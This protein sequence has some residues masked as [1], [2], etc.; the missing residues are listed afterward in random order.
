MTKIFHAF[1]CLKISFH[2]YQPTF[3][4]KELFFFVSKSCGSFVNH[5]TSKSNVCVKLL[6]FKRNLI[7][8][9]GFCHSPRQPPQMKHQKLLFFEQLELE[10]IF[11]YV[12]G[13]LRDKR[14]DTVWGYHASTTPPNGFAK[15]KCF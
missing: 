15:N 4:R 14:F 7:S 5:K 3:G 9:K 11:L 1:I 2:P 8:R 13:Y 6:S 12:S 10:Q